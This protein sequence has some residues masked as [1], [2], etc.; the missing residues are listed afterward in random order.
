MQDLIHAGLTGIE[1][2]ISSCGCISHVRQKQSL[3][4]LYLYVMMGD[5]CL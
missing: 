4:F 2:L 3:H 1:G 5:N